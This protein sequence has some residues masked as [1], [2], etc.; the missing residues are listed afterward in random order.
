MLVRLKQNLSC[1]KGSFKAG[2]TIDL[3]KHLGYKEIPL[4]LKEVLEEIK[5][6]SN[7]KLQLVDEEEEKTK[8]KSSS[9]GNKQNK[10]S[11]SKE[12]K[13][14]KLDLGELDMDV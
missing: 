8:S 6:P 10:N 13:E 1:G 12:D 5:M 11:N 7:L 14:Q 2:E 4:K 3:E 9:K